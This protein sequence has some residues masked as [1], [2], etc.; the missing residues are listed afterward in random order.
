LIEGK[1]VVVLQVTSYVKISLVKIMCAKTLAF[2][3]GSNA[4]FHL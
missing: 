1:T 3:V 2:T 4:V